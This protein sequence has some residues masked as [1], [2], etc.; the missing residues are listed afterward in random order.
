M[1]ILFAFCPKARKTP[2]YR[3]KAITAAFNMVGGTLSAPLAQYALYEAQ[4]SKL[5]AKKGNYIERVLLPAPSSTPPTAA[6]VQSD[7]EDSGTHELQD[8]L[9]DQSGAER[10]GRCAEQADDLAATAPTSQP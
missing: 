4:R 3:S 6:A 5:S 10:D 7:G 2:V 9:L 8:P 1:Y